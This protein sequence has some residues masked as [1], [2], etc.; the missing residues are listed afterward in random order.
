MPQN[1]LTDETIKQ[2]AQKGRDSLFFL[3]KAILGFDKFDK[4]I[5]KPLCDLLQNYETNKRVALI[6]PRGWYKSTMATI[7]YPIWRA[8][9][10]PAVRIL[11]VQN[12][13][14]N[15]CGKLG[16]I[17]QIFESNELF[18]LLYPEILPTRDCVWA[19]DAATVNRKGAYPEATWEAAGTGTQK[20]GQHY[21]VIIEDDTVSPTKDNLT[22]AMMQPTEAEIEKA[23]GW[24]RLATP[25]LIEPV[26][27]Q[28]V[29]VGTRWAENDLLGFIIDQHPEYHQLTRAVRETDH[30]P[31]PNGEVQW[32]ARFNEDVLK[33]VETDLGPYMYASLYLNSPTDAANQIF[34]REWINYF[35]NQPAHLICC[36][37]VDLA[38]A[39]KEE[40]SNPDYNVILT[41]G[42]NT[43]NGHI[44]V[45]HYT[46]ER[47]SPSSVIS[48]I[49]DHHRLY[50]P[51]KVIVEGIGY[52]RTLV[53]WLEQR[54]RKLNEMF[55]V[56][57]I[58]G[59]SGSKTDRIRGLQPYFASGKIFLRAGMDHLERELLAFPKAAHDD[60]PD[61]LSLQL[62]FWSTS[63][64]LLTQEK[65][66]RLAR[67]PFSAD[68]IIR[69]IQERGAHS[70]SYPNDIGIM[71]HR[72]DEWIPA[73]QFEESIYA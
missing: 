50:K 32:E 17:K 2:L 29:V 21:D 44:Y 72:L 45:L 68:V 25:L 70:N 57:T 65:D 31:D 37:S 19:K 5:H 27:S 8:I 55:Y 38:S 22:G 48:S 43:Q 35:Q 14:T 58:K 73:R 62:P 34:K 3:A 15:A 20:T 49:F 18:K 16:A 66:E 30:K 36:T 6:L 47:M 71:S 63:T 1:K 61:T 42:I 41:S 67:N 28:R 59:H 7:A 24:F 60:V 12:T 9:N 26:D 52:Q 54:Q 13:Y 10:N 39:D 11:L 23:I 56:E 33:A 53:H 46:R 64:S 51:V 69:E 40:S 4:E